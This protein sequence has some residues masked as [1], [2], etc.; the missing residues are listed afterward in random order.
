M[1]AKF[2]CVVALV[3]SLATAAALSEIEVLEAPGTGFLKSDERLVLGE[4]MGWNGGSI[5]M[6]GSFLSTSGSFSMGGRRLL[7]VEGNA[8]AEETQT[9]IETLLEL[10]SM[11]EN[12]SANY[13]K[14]Q[15]MGR[16]KQNCVDSLQTVKMVMGDDVPDGFVDKMN[17][18]MSAICDSLAADEK[19]ACCPTHNQTDIDEVNTLMEVSSNPDTLAVLQARLDELSGAPTC[20]ANLCWLDSETKKVGSWNTISIQVAGET[21]YF[22][23]SVQ[24]SVTKAGLCIK[25]RN[26]AAPLACTRHKI[27]DGL[28]IELKKVCTASDIN[29]CGWKTPVDGPTDNANKEDITTPKWQQAMEDKAGVLTSMVCTSA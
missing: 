15:I 22:K 27:C 4:S 9:V 6:G 26:A 18:E 19:P 5:A 1:Q 24:A 25:T 10:G 2:L 11:I 21:N 13:V 23:G 17:R 3:V 14:K 28:E 7:N 8:T 29:D 20:D 12:H 16:S